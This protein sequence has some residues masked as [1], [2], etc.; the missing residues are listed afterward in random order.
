NGNAAT[1]ARFI[2]AGY[3]SLVALNFTDTTSL[4][5]RIAAD[6]RR[7]RHYR[8]IQIV[9][10]GIE[11]PPIGQGTYVIWRYEQRP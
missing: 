2:A 10:Y 11:I 7:N 4:D 5:H 3:F 8:I 1:F 6:L 9:P